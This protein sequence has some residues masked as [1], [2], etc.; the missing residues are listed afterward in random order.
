MLG[1]DGLDEMY[2]ES[3]Y[4]AEIALVG[5]DIQQ[6][7]YVGAFKLPQKLDFPK[8]RHV[9]TLKRITIESVARILFHMNA[10][11]RRL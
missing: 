9:D 8:R 11:S 4:Q 5:E 1:F 10:L 7:Q 3:H 6:L 2:W